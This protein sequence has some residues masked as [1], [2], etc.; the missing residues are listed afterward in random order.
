MAASYFASTKELLEP[1]NVISEVL[2]RD[3][4]FP[5]SLEAHGSDAMHKDPDY[6]AAYVIIAVDGIEHKGHGLTF[7]VGRGNEIVC[8][9][10]TALLPLVIGKSVLDIYTD[11]ATFWHS[12]TCESQL[13]W[14]GPEKGAV[15][16]AVAAVVNALWDLWGKLEGKPVW[17]LLCDMTPEEIM[18]LIDWQYLSDAL[19][20]EEALEILRSKQSMRSKRI[21]E[22]SKSG[23]P[24]YTTSVGWLGYSDEKIQRLCKEALE[25]GFT[26]FK[27]KVGEDLS[28]DVRRLRVVREQIGNTFPLMTDANQR[29]DVQQAIDHMTALAEFK[30]HW[31]EEPTSPD[32][33]LG[34]AKIGKALR[35]LGIGIAT[36][37][38]CHNRVMFKQFLEAGS[39]DFCQ[40]DS[41]RLG[42]VNEILAVLLLAEKFNVPV[43]PHGGGVGLCE[44]VQHLAIFD[45]VSVSGTKEGRMVEYVDHLHEHFLHPVII[46][47]GCYTVPRSSGYSSEMKEESL[48]QYEYPNGPVW[49][50]QKSNSRQ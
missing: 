37:E 10:I 22:V 30:I 32:D 45:Y 24:A 16:L 48:K 46:K 12:I 15:H 18:S 35:P 26:K 33:V 39:M 5:T 31:I 7:T 42:G 21:E 13:R 34:H 40:I 41:C 4:R 9:A 23:Y 1:G 50:Q 20:K 8:S 19:T 27:V 36:G 28:D 17:K 47:E 11:F 43:C 3:I 2:I 38:H 49:I 14:I 25:L 44:F 29:W 6:S